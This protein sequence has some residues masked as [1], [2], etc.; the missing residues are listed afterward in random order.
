MNICAFMCVREKAKERESI[1]N[2]V[3]KFS[4]VLEAESEAEVGNE[5]PAHL[6]GMHS[7]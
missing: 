1:K 7:P 2:Y 5:T 6:C 3:E 4:I